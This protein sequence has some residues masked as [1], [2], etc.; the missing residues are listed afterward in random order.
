LWEPDRHK[1]T[2]RRFGRHHQPNSHE[3]Y[4]HPI[5]EEIKRYTAPLTSTTSFILRWSGWGGAVLAY[6]SSMKTTL[7][8]W[9]LLVVVL[10][11]LPAH[12]ATISYSD[13]G[14]F[15]ASTPTTPFSGP[16]EAWAFSL[17]GT[18]TLTSAARLGNVI[19]L[20][21][22]RFFTAPTDYSSGFLQVR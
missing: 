22:L 10:C 11:C 21:S 5:G 6:N 1:P 4:I 3:D 16:S 20:K 2:P 8:C 9:W 17:H 7:N 13:S 15:T 14:T 12:A 18:P 19:P